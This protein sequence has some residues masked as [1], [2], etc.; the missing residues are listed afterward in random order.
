MKHAGK[1][2]EASE[3]WLLS[4]QKTPTDLTWYLQ[5]D[6]NTASECHIGY[7]SNDY[8]INIGA[9][10]KIDRNAG[11]CLTRAQSNFWLKIDP[12]CY[13]EE[14][15][16]ECDQSF[17]ANLI[18][19]NRDSPTIYVLEG[20][21]SEPAFGSIKLSVKSK[22]FGENSC[23][24]EST[25]WSALALLE[26]GHNIEEFIPY[27]VAMSDT[28]KQY[29]PEAFIYMLT[30]YEDYATQLIANQKLGNYW[31]APSSAYNRYYD[32]S[33]ALIALGSSSSEQITKSKDWLLFSQGTNGC[34]QNSV[35][36]TAAVLWALAGRTGKT[37]GGG[38]TYCSEAG[39]FC[40]PFSDCPSSEDV[41]N[42]YF[43][44]SLLTTCCM[45]ENLKSC[46]EYDGQECS[47]EELCI[48]NSKKATDTTECCIGECKPRPQETEC[49]ENFYTCMDKCS[50]YQ[51]PMTTYS[52]NSPQ[53]CCRTKTKPE[54]SAWWLWVLIILIIAVLFGIGYFFRDKL[55]NLFFK[56]KSKFRKGKGG[57]GTSPQGP[58]G[59]PKPGFPPVRRPRPPLP[60]MQQ[61]QHKDNAMS[62]TFKKLKEMS[63]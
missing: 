18:Y 53:V 15:S 52:C 9:N 7:Q 61:R 58:G 2:T 56:L 32:T 50:E 3:K 59:P 14:F 57:K 55:K 29:S 44:P 37:S 54:K 13:E 19:K 62:E 28:N 24:Y 12:N 22:C 17:I 16:I 47:S 51:E 27:I 45:T 8:I 31:E 21:D 63:G 40:I 5:Q 20:T 1:D 38:T 42:N 34:W 4:Q 39:Y 35:R 25:I 60:P 30:N 23:N 6:S 36:E 43:C 10:K 46:S 11:A 49:E 48:G 33:I 26:T 41:G